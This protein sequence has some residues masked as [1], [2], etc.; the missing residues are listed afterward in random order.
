MTRRA[1]TVVVTVQNAVDGGRVPAAQRYGV[2]RAARS[3]PSVRGELT[4]RIVDAAR[5]RT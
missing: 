3:P 5:A 4:V 1:R 2:G